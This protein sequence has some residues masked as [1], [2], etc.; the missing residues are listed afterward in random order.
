MMSDQAASLEHA[1]AELDEANASLEWRVGHPYLHEEMAS[2]PWEQYAYD[3]R[4][5]PMAGARSREWTAIA[6][7]EV[8]VVREM[9][10]CL[11]DIAAGRVP[12]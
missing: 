7:G 2:N 6:R 9:A 1:W 3:P 11:V 4:E 5:R 12:T 8:E 10:R